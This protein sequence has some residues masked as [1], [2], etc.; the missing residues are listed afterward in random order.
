MKCPK[1]Y[2]YATFFINYL[3]ISFFFRTFAVVKGKRK[4]YTMEPI[5]YKSEEERLEAVRRMIGLRQVFEAHVR[6]IMA[7]QTD[8]QFAQ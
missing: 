1:N 3:Q 5:H 6:E 2:K 4:G 8:L 7:K